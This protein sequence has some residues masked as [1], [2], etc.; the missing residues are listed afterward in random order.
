MQCILIFLSNINLSCK[1]VFFL[2]MSKQICEFEII[3]KYKRSQ[4][5]SLFLLK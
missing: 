1:L 3:K 4:I 2:E 5:V